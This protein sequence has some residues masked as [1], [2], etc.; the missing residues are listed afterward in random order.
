MRI[1]DQALPSG[2]GQGGH[3]EKMLRPSKVV[4]LTMDEK[5]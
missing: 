4:P 1:I 2:N 5:F 3:I